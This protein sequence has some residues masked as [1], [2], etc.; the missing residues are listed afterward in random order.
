[1]TVFVDTS[2]LL[3]LLD[4]DDRD[5]EDVVAALRQLAVAREKLV[6]SSYTLVEAGALVKRRLGSEAFRRLGETMAAAIDVVWVDE[7]LHR[8]AWAMAAQHGRDGPS[9][10]DCASF[11]AMRDAH[12]TT[13]L[14]LDQHFLA[15][16]FEVLPK[17]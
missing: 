9:L 11:L 13:A 10:V 3:P 15:E 16:G 12:V 5:H 17:R 14:T 8:R 2:A 6:T 7:E 1:M 4:Q